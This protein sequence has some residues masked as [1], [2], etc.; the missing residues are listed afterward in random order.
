[1]LVVFLV[2][3]IMWVVCFVFR[4]T[5]EFLLGEAEENHE[6]LEEQDLGDGDKETDQD[7]VDAEKIIKTIACPAVLKPPTSELTLLLFKDNS[8]KTG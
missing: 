2:L 6:E 4:Q 3:F 7:L 8:S 5:V 1:M